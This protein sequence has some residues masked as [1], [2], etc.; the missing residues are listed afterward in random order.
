MNAAATAI[1][2]SH[3]LSAPTLAARDVAIIIA[4]NPVHRAY[5]NP[6]VGRWES[7]GKMATVRFSYGR[8]IVFISIS[9]HLSS[10]R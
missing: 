9:G 7:A 6:C 1:A 8:S 4:R 3:F 2:T 5:R 10:S